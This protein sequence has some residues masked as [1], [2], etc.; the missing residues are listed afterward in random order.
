MPGLLLWGDTVRSAA[1]RHEVPLAI[2]SPLLFAEVDGRRVVLTSF[3]ERDRVTHAL[4]DAEV[5][6]WFDFGWKDL[7]AGG[8]SFAE[9]DREVVTRVVRR[10][11][12]DEAIVPGDFP[13][14]L[15]DRLRADG[16][17]LTVDDDAV[18]L[19]RRAKA[20]VELD[21]IRAAQRAAEAGMSAA[22][23]LLSRARPTDDGHL[24]ID[25][26]RLLAVDVRAALRAACA[27]QGAPCPPEVIVASVWNGGG[28]EP[29]SGPLP[30]GLPIVVDIW[31]RHEASG[32][33]A[34]MTR[35]FVVGTPSP[36]HAD[37][38][39]EYARVVRAAL[40][41]AK[42]AIRPGVSGGELFDLTCELFESEG[43]LTQR[44]AQRENE[45]EG[46]QSWLGHGV[47][48]D[49]HESPS[50]A[51]AGRDVLVA[52]DVLAIEPVLWNSGI[53]EV[54]FEDLVLVTEH[55]CETLTRFPYDIA[56]VHVEPGVAG[57][58]G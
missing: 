25:G 55:G 50:L 19:R 38:I 35:T 58:R 7:V 22:S 3:L 24:Q 28:H 47:G 57:H 21:G 34:D 40:E 56:A 9:A 4:P 53:G 41:R 48:L 43:H 11:G 1:L 29:G 52:G 51:P 49:V 17:V 13:L 44:T 15:G 16:I 18:E 26:E 36:E 33:W 32:C 20:G 27:E 8:M 46:F 31:P 45:D 14:A 2:I 6:D 37:V 10:I 39:A 54:R 12:I 30:S 5:L 23:G 42:A